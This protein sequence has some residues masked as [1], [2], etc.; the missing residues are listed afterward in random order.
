[1]RVGLNSAAL[2]AGG[3]D[4]SSA[5]L[6]H[7]NCSAYQESNGMVW[8]E[9][10]AREGS[11]GTQLRTNNTHAS[12]SNVIIVYP[13]TGENG[14]SSLPESFPF[15]CSYPLD[16]ETSLDVAIRP[17]LSV[18]AGVVGTGPKARASMSLYRNG[19]YTDP[20]SAGLIVLPLGTSLHVGVSVMEAEVNGFAV[21]LEEC[22]ATPSADSD[23][24]ER[25]FLIQN[26]CPSDHRLVTVEESGPSLPGRFT[27]TLSLLPGSYNT[28]YLHCRARMCNPRQPSCSQRCLSRVARSVS[29]EKPLTIGPISWEKA[30]E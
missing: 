12:Y 5:H 28:I 16:S 18:E 22:Y 6:A 26:R 4:A 27:A 25:F 29:S 24:P 30:A 13:F 2:L 23:D 7:F 1:M 10:L 17:R 21:I 8:F 19:D 20:Y 3:L 15:S 9:V 14:S 11:C